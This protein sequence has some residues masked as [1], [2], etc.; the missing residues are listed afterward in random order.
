M[1]LVKP[2]QVPELQAGEGL[3]LMAVD[4][5]MALDSATL[6]LNGRTFGGGVL[7]RMEPGTS[8]RL[9]VAD[10]GEYR[11]TQVRPFTYAGIR[12]DLRDEDTLTFRTQPRE[13][14]Y[15]G[16]LLFRPT[17]LYSADIR[18]V[19]RSLA[20]LDWLHQ[21]HPAVLHKYGMQFAGQYPDP[22]PDFFRKQ[23][24]QR[25]LGWASAVEM[26]APPA[27]TALALD[28]ALLFKHGQVGDAVLNASGDL[29]AMLLR[30]GEQDWRVVAVDLRGG[31]SSVVARL[32]DPALDMQWAG[33]R[34]LLFNVGGSRDLMQG[35]R[36]PGPAGNRGTPERLRLPPG[37]VVDVLPDD[38][39]HV[40]YA[41][42]TN[43]GPLV[44]RLDIS[45]NRAM[46]ASRA[47]FSQRLNI[48]LEGDHAWYADGH[49]QLRMAK[50]RRDGAT[51]LVYGGPG[52]WHD[53]MTL[54][55][56]DA[57]RP[58]ALSADGL[59]LYA[60]TDQDREQRELVRYDIARREI[61]ETLFS[62][63]GI[64][65]DDVLLDGRHRLIG[66]SWYR[67]GQPQ[68]HYFDSADTHLS[69]LLAEAFKDRNVV[70][71]ARSADGRQRVLQVDAADQAPRYYHLDVAARSAS[72]V[73]DDMPWLEGRTLS[74]GR[75]LRFRSSDGMD[76]EAFLTLPA[77]A[78]KGPFPLV[79]HPHGGPIGVAD[80]LHFDPAVQFMASLGYAV[81][82]INYRGSKGYG[83]AFRDAGKAGYGS[84]IEDDIDA[85]VAAALAAAPLQADRMC[86]VGASYGG[87]SA[88]MLAMRWP[89]RFRCVVSIAGVAD[90]VL[91]YTASDGAQTERG[92]KVLE[93]LLGDPNK[94][95][96]QML[97]TSPLY[98]YDQLQ[99]PVMLVHGRQDE[100]VDF[101]HTR[102]M[103]RMLGLA[104]RAPVGLVFEKEGHGGW[105]EENERAL[106]TAVAGFLQRHLPVGAAAS[107]A[108][109][110]ASSD[111]TPGATDTPRPPATP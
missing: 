59:S 81:L 93:T 110:S 41:R 92:R 66:V 94:E 25:P 73:E 97:K 77:Q 40:L 18:M 23:V 37:Q 89:Q 79:V 57:F 99:A 22:F 30:K 36:Y 96:E 51:V 53:L 19:N 104:G 62:R 60:V 5:P 14:S 69:G 7:S 109:S 55:A 42:D 75:L 10:A 54:D 33:D 27:A 95:L 12:Y 84:L 63:P 46:D 90:R 86:A 106:W 20:A 16:D 17:G 74:P 65:A 45:S 15:P 85:A 21:Q 1:Q 3:V 72:L 58:V 47:R 8:Y 56:N 26:P 38:D 44:Q 61:V 29:L 82:Q 105:T 43:D 98:H 78:G 88:M 2:G 76:M 4:T 13:I 103:Q 108:P 107:S 67:G 32:G 68:H 31:R 9:F 64:D 28:P 11:W 24:A 111:A 49:G 52:Q 35:L 6:N 70:T 48:G 100:R 71:V 101:E 50:V 80:S 102:R 34:T 91:F 39:N 87:Y 83:R